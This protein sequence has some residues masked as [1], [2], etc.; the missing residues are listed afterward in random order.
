[1]TARGRYI[2]YIILSLVLSVLSCRPVPTPS[3]AHFTY[4][5]PAFT[6]TPPGLTVT[7]LP[8]PTATVSPT[9]TPPPFD[10]PTLLGTISLRHLPAQGRDPSDLAVVNGRVYVANRMTANVSIIEGDE[11]RSVVAV[12]ERPVAIAADPETGR[13]YVPCEGDGNLYVIE[14]DRVVKAIPVGTEPSDVLVME[15]R[16]YVGSYGE[17]AVI[18]L[19]A[20]TGERVTLVRV[21]E[22]GVLALAGDPSR[23]HL[24]VNVY[25]QT[26]VFDTTKLE[27]IGQVNLNSYVTLG[28]NPAMGRFYL[29]DWDSKAYRQYLAA[30]D[31]DTLAVLVRVPVGGDPQGMAVDAGADRLYVANGSGEVTVI[32]ASTHEVIASVV[33][34]VRPVAVAVDE[35]SH[36]VYVA[37]ADSDNVVVLD[38]A[39]NQ[40]LGVIPV[41]IV[42]R[43]IAVDPTRGRTYVAVPATA[44]LFVIEDRS[45]IAEVPVG[46]HPLNVAVNPVTN[47]IYVANDASATISVVDGD[48][49]SVVA[50]LPANMYPLAVAVDPEA[51]RVYVGNTV[52][53]ARTHR[54]V[55]AYTLMTAYK[56]EVLPVEIH[57]DPASNRLYLVA[58]NGIPGSNGGYIVYTLDRRT[59]EPLEHTS[60]AFSVTGLAIDPERK[61]LYATT[62]RFSYYHIL[63]EDTRDFTTIGALDLPKYPECLA[64]NPVTRHLF[65]GL[66]QTYRPDVPPGGEILVLDTRGLGEVARFYLSGDPLYTA[67]DP[68]RGYVYFS[69]TDGTIALIQDVV[70]PAPPTPTPT[71][72][73]TPYRAWTPAPAVTPSPFSCAIQP[74]GRIGQVWASQPEVRLALGC[75]IGEAI[76][77]DM[78]EERFEHGR[79]IWRREGQ[80]IAVLFDDGTW[81][82]HLDTWDESQPTYSCEASPPEGLYQPR[83]GFGK[84]WCNETVV[85]ELLGWASEEERGFRGR[86]QEYAG[87][88]IMETD[89]GVVWVLAASG[90]WQ[91]FD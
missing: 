15:G 65:I 59:L 67:V 6:S 32:Q 40:V 47:R 4:T 91:R 38:G 8:S 14:G 27:E 10:R 2:I 84:V 39:T 25:N 16:V 60:S 58:F 1:M 82:F 72:T 9:F 75:P 11:V 33:V 51:D 5:P 61:E 52:L 88:T 85:R 48:A 45:V 74:T 50:E 90:R 63:A 68:V 20:R 44:S 79:M 62:V 42:P 76:E 35:E 46:M 53:D 34:G 12:G 70:M 36:R 78:A 80:S 24:Y 31:V 30:L 73:P 83:R 71:F 23:H 57:V 19:D 13:V 18:V 29:N 41:G 22:Q 64:Y 26:H 49:L 7:P 69:L 56:S 89:Q 86:C 17:G 87:G 55:A 54:E 21:G 37:V 43:G 28:V 3:V 81:S 77:T 66:S